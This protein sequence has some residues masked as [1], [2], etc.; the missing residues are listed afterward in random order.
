L[1][2]FVGSIF[3]T[4]RNCQRAHRTTTTLF[5]RPKSLIVT[6]R[7]HRRFPAIYRTFA[8]RD[9]H[10]TLDGKR[11]NGIEVLKRAAQTIAEITPQKIMAPGLPRW[12]PNKLKRP[13]P[14]SPPR[15]QRAAPKSPKV[16]EG[17][18]GLP[19]APFITGK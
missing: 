9:D 6:V 5:A 13:L 14:L 3:G 16:R 1:I 18:S 2:E 15:A 12:S 17:Y 8:G 10:K 4:L 11:S 7:T 19:L